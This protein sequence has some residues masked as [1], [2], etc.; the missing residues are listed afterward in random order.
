[1]LITDVGAVS[2][3]AQQTPEILQIFQTIFDNFC[4]IG[5]QVPARVCRRQD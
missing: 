5:N 1:M 4:R 2:M 3:V